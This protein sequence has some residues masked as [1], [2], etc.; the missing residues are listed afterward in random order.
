MQKSQVK[1]LAHSSMHTPDTK[2]F[3]K[4][5]VPSSTTGISGLHGLEQ[6]TAHAWEEEAQAP[7][8]LCSMPAPFETSI[9]AHAQNS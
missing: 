6:S 7:L 3:G 1:A 2:L 5:K 9:Y 8:G 4:N